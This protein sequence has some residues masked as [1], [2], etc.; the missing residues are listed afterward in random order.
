M[1]GVYSKGKGKGLLGILV[2]IVKWW[3]LMVKWLG[4]VLG[5]LILSFFVL[6]WLF[7]V[8]VVVMIFVV[9]VFF[10]VLICVKGI[11]LNIKWLG[12]KNIF[13]VFLFGLVLE[14]YRWYF[15]LFGVVL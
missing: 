7:L 11:K 12:E 2:G 15:F 10:V 4:W 5:M 9:V 1:W 6:I 3:F 14:F 13:I 8:V